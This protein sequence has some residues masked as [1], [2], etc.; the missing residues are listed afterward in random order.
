MYLN[1]ELLSGHNDMLLQY[2]RGALRGVWN[3]FFE[4][5]NCLFQLFVVVSFIDPG[6]IT[7]DN[8]NHFKRY[9]SHDV[10]YPAGKT[11]STCHTL[12]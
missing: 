8:V 6:R 1:R 10:L 3:W 7:R 4:T 2:A 11:C 9:P 12:K 5:P